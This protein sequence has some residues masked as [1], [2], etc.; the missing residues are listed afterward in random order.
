MARTRPST[1]TTS[2]TRAI[3]RSPD[4]RLRAA[5]AR[6]TVRSL[7]AASGRRAQLAERLAFSVARCWQWRSGHEASLDSLVDPDGPPPARR[8]RVRLLLGA[9]LDRGPD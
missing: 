8:P 3:R 9:H 4:R 6:V 5:A 1:R 2:P 7:L